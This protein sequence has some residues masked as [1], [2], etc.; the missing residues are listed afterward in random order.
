VYSGEMENG[1][2]VRGKLTRNGRLWDGSE[3]DVL[4]GK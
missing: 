3:S 4:S 1:E 2:P